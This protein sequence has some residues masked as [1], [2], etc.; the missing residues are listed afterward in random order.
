MSGARDAHFVLGGSWLS[1]EPLALADG[2]RKSGDC[3]QFPMSMLP[4]SL[5]VLETVSC[6]FLDRDRLL[7][8]ESRVWLQIVVGEA[9]TIFSEEEH[10]ATA[11]VT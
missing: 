1:P 2:A 3:G 11:T 6:W 10:C 9:V 7:P 5:V 4:N 8:E